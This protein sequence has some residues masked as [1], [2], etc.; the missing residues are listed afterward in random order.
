MTSGPVREIKVQP[1]E[2]LFLKVR[3]LGLGVE[4]LGEGWDVF[5]F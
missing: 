3:D 5:A 1:S 4:G 2:K